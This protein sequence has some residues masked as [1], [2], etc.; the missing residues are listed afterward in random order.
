MA[1]S[2]RPGFSEWQKGKEEALQKVTAAPLWQ[3]LSRLEIETH[4]LS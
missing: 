4:T 1:T 2:D 3:G